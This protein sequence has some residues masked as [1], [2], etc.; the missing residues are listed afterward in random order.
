MNR[1]FTN[2]LL[3]GTLGT[4]VTL[5]SCST[6]RNEPTPS[7]E[8]VGQKAFINLSFSQ[9]KLGTYAVDT[10]ATAD[11]VKITSA[12]IF[13]FDKTTGAMVKHQNILASGLNTVTDNE[14]SL[15]N[16]IETTTGD[17]VVLIGVN[18]PA[19]MVTVINNAGNLAGAKQAVATLST[20]TELVN[21][22]GI[23]MFS[24]TEVSV[25]PQ[26]GTTESAS[27]TVSRMVAKVT[28]ST[29]L[30]GRI[31]VAGGY[32][33]IPSLGF[34]LGNINKT[35]YPIQQLSA[36]GIPIVPNRAAAPSFFTLTPGSVYSAFSAGP[37]GGLYAVENSPK[38]V[39]ATENETTYVS[40]KAAFIPKGFA[41][42]NGTVSANPNT[43]I[44]AT[45]WTADKGT[46]TAKFYFSNLTDATTYAGATG[47]V[48]QY[49]GGICYY[50]VAVRTQD[51]TSKYIYSIKRNNYY[52]INITSILGLGSMDPEAGATTPV[53]EPVNITASITVQ[54]WNVV[55]DDVQLTP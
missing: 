53:P 26:S 9:H 14:Y 28:V 17:K 38:N 52:K 21:L 4:A 11:E 51:S 12:D 19:S 15:K 8:V 40:V 50:K 36:S 1:I 33:D 35:L 47:K 25:T 24:T 20:A 18:L 49:V 10:N 2:L 30:T 16:P 5:T 22:D 32:I 55:S 42:S 31:E 34:A 13:I 43:A 23:S 44:A 48:E 27:V 7:K 37:A 39:N 3:A 6:E 29:P 46:G 45:F 54:P 41:D